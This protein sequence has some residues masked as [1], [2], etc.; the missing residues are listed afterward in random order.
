MHPLTASLL[1]AWLV[2]HELVVTSPVNQLNTIISACTDPRWQSWT[3]LVTVS[4]SAPIQVIWRVVPGGDFMIMK[5][6]GVEYK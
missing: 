1:P 6:E 3:Q 5:V 2:S 4:K